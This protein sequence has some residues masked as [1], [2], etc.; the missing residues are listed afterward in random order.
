MLG[1]TAEITSS[2]QPV[3]L[4]R[5]RGEG[6][7]VAWPVRDAEGAALAPRHP[8]EEIRG[9]PVDPFDEEGIGQGGR[10]VQGQ[11]VDDVRRH[12]YLVSGGELADAQ[13]LREAVGSAYVG[14]EVARGAPL[15]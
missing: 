6:D 1:T 3:L 13:G 9:G 15:D 7:A 5:V 10:H 14:H 2:A 8:L 11:L 12:R 4:L